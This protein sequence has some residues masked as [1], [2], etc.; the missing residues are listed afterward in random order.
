MTNETKR[1]DEKTNDLAELESALEMAREELKNATQEGNENEVGYR[2]SVVIC[3]ERT[4][5]SW[6]DGKSGQR[7]QSEEHD[8][9]QAID[10]KNT[11]IK[12]SFPEIVVRRATD[13][14]ANPHPQLTKWASGYAGCG[15]PWL[16]IKSSTDGIG[17]M[18]ALASA[19]IQARQTTSSGR[20]HYVSAVDLIGAI[21]SANQYGPNNK[22]EVLHSYSI[23]TLLL[24]G[25][26]GGERADRRTLDTMLS[27][28][29]ARVQDMLPTVIESSMGLS[30]WVS[31]YQHVNKADALNLARHV[32]QGVKGWDPNGDWSNGF[33]DL[34]E[35][36]REE[37]LDVTYQLTDS[38]GNRLEVSRQENMTH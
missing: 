18:D 31:R 12:A 36:Q 3:L 2:R 26:I 4:I 33:I 21:D 1:D 11:L 5:K 25:G 7:S 14:A 17:G 9:P 37:T 38:K 30:E 13:I 35:W 6:K 16:W 32:M 28:L 24:L 10:P 27:L 19:A 34:Q 29:W 15:T 23:Y 20:I 22:R 8:L